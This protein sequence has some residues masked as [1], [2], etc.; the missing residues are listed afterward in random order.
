M[1]ILEGILQL[2]FEYDII[3]VGKSSEYVHRTAKTPRGANSGGFL[4]LFWRRWLIP[5][6]GCRQLF[7]VQPF[8]NVVGNYTCHNRNKKSSEHIIH[9]TAP[10]PVPV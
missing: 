2:K 4:C 10:L 3:A 9:R 6:V 7:S 1:A 8:A 5:Q